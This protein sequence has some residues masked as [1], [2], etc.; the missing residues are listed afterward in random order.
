MRDTTRRRL[1]SAAAFAAAG[2]IVVAL[3]ASHGTGFGD[4]R[5]GHADTQAMFLTRSTGASSLS[6]PL[7]QASKP[8][9]K[10]RARAAPGR[11]PIY[12]I[13]NR[14]QVDPRVAYYIQGRD[15][16]VYFTPDGVTLTLTDEGGRSARAPAR[17][18][19]T[20]GMRWAVKQE[21]LGASPA[22][23]ATGKKP[24][25]AVISYFKGRRAEWR[26]ALS[27]YS[28]LLYTELWPG[29]DLAYSGSASKL[30]YTF[31]L[32]PGADPDKIRLA[33]RGA[34]SVTL[35]EAGQL[36]V[37]TPVARLRDD[38]PLAYQII[39][40][41]RVQVAAAF[42]LE[43][44]ASGSSQS[45]GFHLGGYDRSRPLMLDPAMLVYAGFIGG[46]GDDSG[47]DIA[48]DSAGNAYVTGL[49]GSTEASLP[50][51]VG[52]DLTYNG[53]TFDAFVAK[54]NPAGTGLIYAGYIGGTGDDGG[55]GIAVDA[56]GNAYVSGFTQSSQASFPVTVGPDET[57]NG[58]LFDAFVAK[59]D[60][61]GTGLVYAGYIGGSGQDEGFDIAVDSAGDAYVDGVTPSSEASF[62]VT[63]GPDVTYNGGG[64]DG[65]VAKVN[66]AG[67]ALDYAGYIGGAGDD[68]AVGIAVDSVGN[69]YV[70]GTTSSSQA[71]FPVTVG[72]DL[73]YNG[74]SSDGFVAKV[75]AAGTALAYAG[76]IG[77]GSDDSGQDIAVDSGG[78]AHVGGYT[79]STEASFPVSVG[80]DLTYN[81]GS[82]DGFVAKV[83]AAGT[84]L[85]Y[86]GYIGGS[87]T[88][89][90]AGI[91]VDSS[92]SV[93]LTGY[94]NTSE[95]SF[96]VTG[97]PD[98]TYNGA[99]DGFAAKVNA[100]G[101]GF[102]YAGYIGGSGNDFGT[103]NA[104]DGAGDAY[105][106]GSTGS[107]ET[108]FPVTVG[109]DLTYNGGSRDAFVAKIA[110]AAPPEVSTPGEAT[111]GGFIDPLTGEALDLAA[112]LV[113]SS[114]NTAS[115]NGKAT[116]GFTVKCCSGG[117]TGNLTYNDHAAN[118]RIK[119]TSFTLL[120][121]R[122]STAAECLTGGAHARFRGTADEN[123]TPGHSIRVDV[124]D[125]GEPGSEG[126][127]P[128]RFEIHV[129]EPT[130]YMAS[131]V[132]VGG[133]I[134]VRSA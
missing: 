29:I 47:D 82:S 5:H 6:P 36:E 27:T 80:P 131:G 66:A 41:R 20:L 38:R 114:S 54:V 61:A 103:D 86:A 59:V 118:E 119:A 14:G 134:Q 87:G 25:R 24:T 75:N 17:G 78:A 57:Y 132:L 106:T 81:G 45:Y 93:D 70:G 111:G 117:V 129:D 42:R 2:G 125:C 101:S 18:A 121:I 19:A 68:N 124:D 98:V 115:V 21:F 22:A 35:N 88:D 96:P 64:S 104:V 53:G 34:T 128:D 4:G 56:A 13:E 120:S 99:F 7:E 58:G 130:G 32:K 110:T 40:G 97:G 26:T 10:A 60:P 48:V 122:A 107:S 50:V 90:T 44:A 39:D 63:V 109:P 108:S 105:V 77:G 76:Y 16:T 1:A 94:T 69:A 67:S 31:V 95:A 62:P 73:T 33:Y 127:A 51:T 123:G 116:L 102:A 55:R 74:G 84:A 79:S 89:V 30:E 15:T 126:T 37:S 49:T 8:E 71:T 133:N 113:Q 12:F 46:S 3:A 112:L 9:I 28:E 83:N 92:G 91:S 100:G 43:P 23:R 65:F 52:P 85:D 11:L 72:P